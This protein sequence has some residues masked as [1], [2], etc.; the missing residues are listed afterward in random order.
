[1]RQQEKYGTELLTDGNFRPSRKRL[2][3]VEDAG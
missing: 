3:Y 2:I 1:M